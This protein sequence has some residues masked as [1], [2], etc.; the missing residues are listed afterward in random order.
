MIDKKALRNRIKKDN[1][2]NELEIIKFFQNPHHAH[3]RGLQ[4]ECSICGRKDYPFYELCSVKGSP[5]NFQLVCFECLK[6]NNYERVI[7]Y[8]KDNTW[9]WQKVKSAIKKE[10]INE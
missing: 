1:E 8:T 10:E 3:M 4:R 5:K 6:E 2:N 9:F 7:K